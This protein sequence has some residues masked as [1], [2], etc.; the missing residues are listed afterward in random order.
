MPLLK[1]IGHSPSGTLFPRYLVKGL[2]ALYKK[3]NKKGKEY[4]KEKYKF[5]EVKKKEVVAY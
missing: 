3:V 4:Y 2:I 5:I 1:D